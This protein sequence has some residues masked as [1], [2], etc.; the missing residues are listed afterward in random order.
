MYEA[1]RTEVGGEARGV[2]EGGSGW[3][4]GKREVWL[5]GE[6]RG[7]VLGKGGR[8]GGGER[9]GGA[10]LEERDGV[11]GH[12]REGDEVETVADKTSVRV[13]REK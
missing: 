3:W 7:G 4:E 8:S 6:K 5:G 10:E 9:I 1:V 12:F 2:G 13:K 11:E